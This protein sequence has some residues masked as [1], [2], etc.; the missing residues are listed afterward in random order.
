LTYVSIQNFNFIFTDEVPPLRLRLFRKA[1]VEEKIHSMSAEGGPCIRPIQL[2]ITAI[3]RFNLPKVIQEQLEFP[4]A[5]HRAIAEQVCKVEALEQDERYG[6]ITNRDLIH[7][8]LYMQDHGFEPFP[9]S[10]LG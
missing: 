10:I 7:L 1:Q 4:S 8:K 5:A 9:V 3:T 6:F 2:N